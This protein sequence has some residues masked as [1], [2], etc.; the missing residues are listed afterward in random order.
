MNKN[1]KPLI[2]IGGVIVIFGAFWIISHRNSN[3][4]QASIMKQYQIRSDNQPVSS[5]PEAQNTTTVELK[6]ADTFNLTA[7]I[8]KKN[9]NGAEVRMLAYNSS[10]PGPVIKVPQGSE[11]TIH[12]T[13]NTD[14]P[15]TLHSHG[16]RLDNAFDGV[17]DVTQKQVDV[18]Q[19][20]DYKIK[21]PDA[22]LYWYHPHIREDYT[23]QSGL[24]GNYLV[25]PN[26]LNYWSP[27]N[28]EQ[29]LMF[30]DILLDGNNIAGFNAQNTDHTL[31]GRFGN[32]LLINGQS[33]YQMTVD[34]GSVFRF[35][36][37]NAANTRPFK[38]TIPNAKMKLVGSDNGKYEKEQWV[39]SVTLGPSERAIVE[40]MFDGTGPYTI[41]NKTPDKTYSLGTI[42]VS[43]QTV[44][45]SYATQFQ[46]LRTNQDVISG[47]DPFMQYFNKQ[48]DKN[49][50][51]TIDMK[52]SMQGMN[53][54]GGMMMGSG[55]SMQGMDMSGSG[56]GD[57]IEWEDNMGSMNA[58]STDQTLQWKI[59]DQNT[60]KANGD[61]DWKF[62]VGDKVKIKI[63]NDKTSMHPMQHPIHF[64]GQ[65]FLVLTTNGVKNTDLVWKDTVLIPSGVTTEILVDMENPGTWMA[66][67][68]IAEHLQDGM[69]FQYK[70]E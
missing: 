16:V 18:G 42:T 54:S 57:G 50:N 65:K 9:I 58:N 39:D 48:P 44:Q 17:P 4:P 37:T 67:C 68:H 3:P 11:V 36:L 40:V 41:E 12:F 55:S 52:G 62:K 43:N 38:I 51:L 47:I 66:H 2:I 24:Y 31:M 27:V 33:N 5:L 53:M 70:V 30:S 8:V 29:I 32:T 22:G 69:M 60:G 61:I 28:Q 34:K 10:V 59:V 14:V 20:F 1:I 19:S 6:N 56:S 15:T 13:N 35:Y 63:T 23:Q 64:H 46:T 7:S 26:D 21:F 49:L 25:V 45:T